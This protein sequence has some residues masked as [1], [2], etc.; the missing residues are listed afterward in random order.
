MLRNL[1]ASLAPFEV[2]R[3]QAA[4][5][6]KAVEGIQETATALRTDLTARIAAAQESLS[7]R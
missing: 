5:A 2:I 1:A 3:R 7:T 4:A 6:A